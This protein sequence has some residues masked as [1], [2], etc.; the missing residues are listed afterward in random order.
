M[1]SDYYR[2][3]SGLSANASYLE[4][5]AARLRSSEIIGQEAQN[6]VSRFVAP[7]CP[8]ETSCDISS[9][10]TATNLKSHEAAFNLIES[11]PKTN[12]WMHKEPNLFCNVK[13]EQGQDP[14]RMEQNGR[15][16]RKGSSYSSVEV[17]LEARTSYRQRMQESR[18]ALEKIIACSSDLEA[19]NVQLDILL[20]KFC[21]VLDGVLGDQEKTSLR[22]FFWKDGDINLV[23]SYEEQEELVN[24][25]TLAFKRTFLGESSEYLAYA[26]HLGEK[27]I[28]GFKEWYEYE[29][30]ISNIQD[31]IEF[32]W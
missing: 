20:G 11:M 24:I 23:D 12:P 30:G 32:A 13:E 22:K 18:R 7:S 29:E 15:Y 4:E 31:K 16:A 2:Q 1:A 17:S 8:I 27:H 19:F 25:L 21:P 10:K 9:S 28:G 5:I 6:E 26:K 14:F 3:Q